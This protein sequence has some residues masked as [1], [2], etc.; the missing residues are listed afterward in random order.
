MGGSC[1]LFF[2][3]PQGVP[4]GSQTPLEH[5]CQ[6][7]PR[8]HPLSTWVLRDSR[9]AGHSGWR[10]TASTSQFSSPS[11]R[12]QD[13]APV[14]CHQHSE[15]GPGLRKDRRPSR[16]LQVGSL[17]A[18]ASLS[19]SRQSHL[20]MVWLGGTCGGH[21]SHSLSPGKTAHIEAKS[22]LSHKFQAVLL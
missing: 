9:A 17:P 12:L 4:R 13:P 8:T 19:W 14:C 15:V 3:I 18:G 21:S 11:P 5:A 22:I 6:P 1:G 10:A 2:H 7:Q 20:Y 16:H